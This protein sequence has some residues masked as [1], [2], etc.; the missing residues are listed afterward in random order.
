MD[1]ALDEDLDNAMGRSNWSVRLGGGTTAYALYALA[2]AVLLDPA[3][4]LCLLSGAYA[5]GMLSET[6]LLP[7]KVPGYVEGIIVLLVAAWRF[8]IGKA[9]AALG[10]MIAVQLSDDLLD[11]NQDQWLQAQ[12]W[13]TKLGIVGTV[14]VCLA[15]LAALFYLDIWLLI[16]TALSFIF[17]QLQERVS[18]R[19]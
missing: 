6:R 16:Y 15:L 3:T 11:R 18:K 10:I 1:D 2:L 14:L 19:G 9:W 12:N 7:T 13:T 5:V 4:G 17:F 8:G